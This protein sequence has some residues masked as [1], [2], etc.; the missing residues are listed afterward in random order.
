MAE[1]AP[2]P[3][4]LVTLAYLKAQL[5]SGSDHLGI[6]MPL[7]LDALAIQSFKSFV[8]T[9]IQESI[10]RLHGIAIPENTVATLLR[11]AVKQK[12]VTRDHGRYQRVVGAKLPTSTIGNRKSAIQEEQAHFAEA[13]IAHAG[14]HGVTWSRDDALAHLYAFLEAQKIG[15]ILEGSAPR[16][17]SEIVDA[18]EEHVLAEFLSGVLAEAGAHKEVLRGM[19]EGIVIYHAA[20]MPDF[21]QPAARFAGLQVAFDGVLIRHALGYEGMAAQ[22]LMK[23]TLDLFLASGIKC[24]AFENT[25]QETLRILD[26]YEVRLANAESRKTLHQVAMARHFLAENFKPSDIREFKTF[27]RRDVARLGFTILPFP[28]RI[29]QY[30]GSEALLAKRFADPRTQDA[31][32]SRVLHDVDCIAAVRTLRRDH[33]G[34]RIEDCKA[35][36][37][38]SSP[39]VIENARKWWDEDERMTTFPPIAHIRALTNLTWLRHPKLCSD[40]KMSELFALCTAAMRPSSQIWRRFIKHLELLKSSNRITSDEMAVM[41]ISSMSDKLLAEI[42][43]TENPEDVDATDLDEVVERVKAAY[44][45]GHQDVVNELTTSYEARLRDT[46]G[47]AAAAKRK[48]EETKL[49]AEQREGRVLLA[50]QA[51]SRKLARFAIAAL[52]IVVSVLVCFGAYHLVF[53]HHF[54]PTWWGKL[55][56]VCIALFILLE[57]W[58]IV[59]HS[60]ELFNRWELKLTQW[61]EHLFVPD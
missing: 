28:P 51:R 54:E 20:F 55:G 18:R 33:R 29:A 21:G 60:K 45:V 44:Q 2:N 48:L 25:L 24:I 58:G 6:F 3:N 31:Q 11:R 40:F 23:E 50:I 49:S 38:T 35:V 7:V 57:T 52:R 46:E 47:Q 14:K 42:D 39:L 5:D 17:F 12:L 22:R 15:F 41:L 19:V 26:V 1:E 53:G 61:I 34:Y 30:T 56:F 10:S 9:E 59:M 37:L 32:D 16:D 4:G 8:T 36:F 27:L 43:L 13:L